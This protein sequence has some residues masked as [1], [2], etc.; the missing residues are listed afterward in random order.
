MVGIDGVTAVAMPT[1]V[2]R[3]LTAARPWAPFASALCPAAGTFDEAPEPS[4]GISGMSLISPPTW[5][6]AEP[7]C[8][9]VPPSWATSRVLCTTPIA[10][11][12]HRTAHAATTK[13]GAATRLVAGILST[14][15]H[16]GLLRSSLPEADTAMCAPAHTHFRV[17]DS[18]DPAEVQPEMAGVVLS[19]IVISADFSPLPEHCI[20]TSIGLPLVVGV[21]VPEADPPS[22]PV[23]VAA[24]TAPARV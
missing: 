18:G 12:I 19:A 21:A 8:E 4:S 22:R 6:T 11:T 7:V 10:R 24:T 17:P 20:A 1:Q 2:P 15:V 14:F 5:L 3:R 23:T 13:S 16:M 9:T